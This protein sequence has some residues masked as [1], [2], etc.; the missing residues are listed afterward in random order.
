MEPRLGIY[1]HI[2]FCAS[3]CGYCDFYSC[4]GAADRMA[5]YQHAL[6]EHIEE[7]AGRIAPAYIDTV[8]FGGGTPSF[9]GAARLIELLDA[10]KATGRLLKRA[11]VTVE[12]NP[13]SV[14][15]HDLRALH[16][17]G[18][19]RLSI[20]MQ[21]ANNDILKMIGRR[22][23][24]HQVEMTVKNA[25]TAGFDNVS[26]DLIYGLPSQT[27]S[28]WA[29]TLAKAI[30][31]RPEHI[32]GYGLKL[33]EGTPMYELKDSPLIPSD[34]EQADMYL[35]MVDE[36]RRYGYEQYEISNF[37]IPGYES[38]HNL[39]YWQLDDYMGFG[40]GAHSCIGRTRYSYVRDLDRYIAGVL[41]GED[42]IDEY[43]TIG[44]F[45]RIS[46]HA[47]NVLE[48]AEEL[49]SK[50][51]S[52]SPAAMAEY[53]TLAR[54]TRRILHL[55]LDSFRQDDPVQAA[56][57]EPLEQVIDTLKEQM[58]TRHILRMQQGTC[59]IEAG[60]VLSDLLTDLERTSDHC[61]NIAGCVIDARAHNLNLHETLRQAKTAD[62]SFQ[63]T[64]ESYVEKYQLPVPSSNV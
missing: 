26:L 11:E 14:R 57:V 9:Y 19:N 24:F 15:L 37:S 43:E 18:F 58:R 2:P 45:E 35:C 54:A 52:F 36:L 42:M 25:R 3:K 33:E 53:Q 13:D 55:S 23:S 20:G 27:R 6:L 47:V 48:S 44:D 17:A 32:S 1:I 7:S 5:D 34:D 31:L 60:F 64:Y 16:K 12:V 30:A 49:Q 59:S 61:S 51:L 40:P 29:D 41:H 22:H 63:Q 38:R 28:D 4:A 56:Q 39:K 10:V 62:G 50:K 21:S 8:Y 46:D